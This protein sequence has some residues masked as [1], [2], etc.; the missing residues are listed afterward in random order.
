MINLAAVYGLVGKL[1]QALPLYEEALRLS[2]AKLG[3]EHPYTLTAMRHLGEVYQ[4]DGKLDL[5]LPLLEE[6][7]RL[8][9]AKLGPDHP[10][11]LLAMNK[12]AVCYQGDGKLDLALPLLEEAL[13]LMKAKLGPDHPETLGSMNDLAKIYWTLRQLDR[14]IPLFEDAVKRQAAAVGRQHQVTLQSVANLGVNYKDAGRLAEALPL[15]EEG[16]RAGKTDPML[17][18][19]GT[20][21]L[22]GYARARK[23]TEATALAKELLDDARHTLPPESAALAAMLAELGGARLAFGSFAD[24]EPLLRECLS[25]RERKQPNSWMTFNTRSR[26]G[27]ALLGQGQFAAAEPLLLA[28]Y[29]GMKVR[30]KW[31]WPCYR[32]SLAEAAD[33][34]VT[35]YTATN[36]TEELKRWQAERAKYP[37]AGNSPLPEKK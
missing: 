21:L 36:R 8:S 28:G 16:H 18:W 15:L 27:G 10:D 31:I 6:A 23:R 3:P 11:T 34:L 17:R 32:R 14:S 37:G 35:L 25:I 7:L 20:Q 33:R 19:V 26:L 13:R 30:E 2:R 4:G 1:D 12:L 29:E 9:R 24:A 5:A 22:D